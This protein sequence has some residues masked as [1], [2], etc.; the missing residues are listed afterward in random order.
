MLDLGELFLRLVAHLGHRFVHPVA[1]QTLTVVIF[2]HKF[3]VEEL[4]LIELLGW[5]IQY[6]FAYLCISP[7]SPDPFFARARQ[8]G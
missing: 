1:M 7:V 5:T 6:L 4:K 8:C 2:A 3:A